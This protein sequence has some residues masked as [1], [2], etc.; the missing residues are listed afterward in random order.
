MLYEVITILGGIYSGIFTP[1]ESAS[2]AVLTAIT[3]GLA[4]GRLRLSDFPRMME[5]SAEV[6]G[7]IGP[8]IGIALLFGQA[9]SVLDVPA[10]LVQ[11]IADFTSS[12]TAI[13]LLMLL[14]FLA[15][16]CVMETTSYNF[17]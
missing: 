10:L 12:E 4:T 9:L 14:V 11:A 17:V 6:N 7:V 16:G 1:T 2:V 3:I 13:I 15:A 5:R 8:I